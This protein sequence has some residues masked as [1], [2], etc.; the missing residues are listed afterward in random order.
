MDLR[1]TMLA[2][3]DH[4]SEQFRK[5]FVSLLP[6]ILEDKPEQCSS[7]LISSACKALSKSSQ[8]ASKRALESLLQGFETEEAILDK[9]GIEYRL[10]SNCKGI[11]LPP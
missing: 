6:E 9:E 3:A 11:R 2:L 10:H 7:E 4:F 8:E 1:T 5:S